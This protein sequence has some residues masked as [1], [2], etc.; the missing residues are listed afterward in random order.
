MTGWNQLTFWIIDFVLLNFKRFQKVTPIL[1]NNFNTHWTPSIPKTR[2]K[3]WL[4]VG[5]LDFPGFPLPFFSLFTFNPLKERIKKPPLSNPWNPVP[6]NDSNGTFFFSRFPFLS[7]QIC[8]AP[9][10]SSAGNHKQPVRRTIVSE[11][12]LEFWTRR[13]HMWRAWCHN[14][15]TGTLPPSGF[16]LH[17]VGLGIWRGGKNGEI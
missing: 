10:S 4:Q 17:C 3:A 1:A 9:R 16:M 11:P 12:E 2:S 14:F 15:W 8:E 6:V 13:G 5:Q 7:P